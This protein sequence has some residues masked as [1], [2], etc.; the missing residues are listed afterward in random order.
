MRFKPRFYTNA[1]N[2][3][4]PQIYREGTVLTAIKTWTFRDRTRDNRSL[5][6]TNN[7]CRS[8]IAVVRLRCLCDRIRRDDT[9]LTATDDGAGSVFLHIFIAIFARSD[10]SV[11]DLVAV[12]P[13]T[14][15]RHFASVSVSD[16][17]LPPKSTTTTTRMRN[18]YFGTGSRH[19][20]TTRLVVSGR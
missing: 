14:V 18:C 11:A 6:P 15:A 9:P 2:R 20:P 16:T 13:P 5:P 8:C 10:R 7:I 1:E 12:A 4:K 17:R 3:R 19:A